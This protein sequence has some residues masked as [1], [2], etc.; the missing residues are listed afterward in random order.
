MRISDWSSDVCSSD[1]MLEPQSRHSKVTSV[2]R[3]DLGE[4][5]WME[6]QATDYTE[7]Q[8][9]GRAVYTRGGCW[10][11]HSQFVRPVTGETRRG[12][13]VAQSGEY[14]VDTPHLFST[15]RIGPDLSRVS[16]KYSDEW[17][18]AHFWDPRMVVPDSI[19]PR[20]AKLFDQVEE[21]VRIVDDN[22]GNRTL[23]R[24]PATETLFDFERQDRDRK[25]TRE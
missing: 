16:L 22:Q 14:A 3:T 9:H 21:P 19:M 4:L 24:T 25:R 11:C 7:L 20:F 13:A 23:E 18:L 10:Y 1:L 12:G 15:R 8:A 2:V 5:K 17:H 6:A